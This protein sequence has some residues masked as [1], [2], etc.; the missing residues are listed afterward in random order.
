MVAEAID[1][2]GQLLVPIPPTKEAQFAPTPLASNAPLRREGPLF[3]RNLRFP[4]GGNGSC[5]K[6]PAEN[7]SHLYHQLRTNNWNVRLMGLKGIQTLAWHNPHDLQPELEEVCKVLADEVNNLCPLACEAIDTIASLC[8]HL[9]QAMHGTAGTMCLDVLLKLSQTT[10]KFILQK[11]VSFQELLVDPSVDGTLSREK[12][13]FT[14][15]VSELISS[16][17]RVPPTEQIPPAE[18][19]PLIDPESCRVPESLDSSSGGNFLEYS[20]HPDPH[21]PVDPQRNK[22]AES[23]IVL[24]TTSGSDQD[25]STN[26]YVFFRRIRSDQWSEKLKGL[27]TLQAAAHLD[28]DLLQPRLLEVFRIL[29]EEVNSQ[30]CIVVCEAINTLAVL[31]LHLAKAMTHEEV[32]TCLSLL[33]KYAQMTN[34]FIYQ[35][36]HFVFDILMDPSFEDKLREGSQLA[37]AACKEAEVNTVCVSPGDGTEAVANTSKGRSTFTIKEASVRPGLPLSARGLILI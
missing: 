24:T 19:L 8:L 26:L 37:V 12:N 10:N 7:M 32:Q 29:E 3:G 11:D 4:H 31:H 15:P 34:K 9:G 27:R 30:H 18:A 13:C 2:E 36:E 22:T 35:R 17:R 28:S 21:L 33:L 6:D 5:T 16:D 1:Q 23:D 20:A 14:E 25:V